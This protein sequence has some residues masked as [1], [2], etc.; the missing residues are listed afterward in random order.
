MSSYGPYTGYGPRSCRRSDQS[1]R[2]DVNHRLLVA[3]Q[4]DASGIE[5]SVDDGV[6][7]LSGTV[8]S[9]W[10]KRRAEEDGWMAAGVMDVI[11]DLKIRRPTS[12]GRWRL[13]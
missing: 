10:A 9:R 2:D 1:V 12:S 8:D 13:N 6:V 5:V 4:L 11:N 3:G 7:T